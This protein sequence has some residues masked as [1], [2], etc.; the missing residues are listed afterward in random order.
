LKEINGV[1]MLMQ[2][3][4]KVELEIGRKEF[5]LNALKAKRNKK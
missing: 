3:E 4:L 1:K 2:K 5:L